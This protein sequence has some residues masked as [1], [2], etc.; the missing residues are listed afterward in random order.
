M[1]DNPR[2]RGLLIFSGGTIAYLGDDGFPIDLAELH[3][4]LPTDG[5]QSTLERLMTDAPPAEA[6]D[7]E[8]ER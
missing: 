7:T 4:G 8:S 1:T 6:D 3:G 2:I 5:E